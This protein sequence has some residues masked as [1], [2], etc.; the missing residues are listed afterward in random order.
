MGRQAK[1]KSFFGGCREKFVA[2]MH[3]GGDFPSCEKNTN[4]AFL[5]SFD[6]TFTQYAT[7][8]LNEEKYIKKS[9]NWAKYSNQKPIWKSIGDNFLS[10]YVRLL[11]H[12]QA[13]LEVAQ[14]NTVWS[15]MPNDDK[16]FSAMVFQIGYGSK[17]NAQYEFFLI[18]FS[19]FTYGVAF[20]DLY[21]E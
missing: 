18:Y 9:S 12:T 17:W 5:I 10:S 15:N 4:C 6:E 3:F 14:M 11:L 19:L 7:P 13:T 1:P 8:Y 16:R 21:F 2:V 20:C